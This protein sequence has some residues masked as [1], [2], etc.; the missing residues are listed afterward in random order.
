MKKKNFQKEALKIKIDHRS[1]MLR[2]SVLKCIEAGGRGHIGAAMSL[3]EIL[4]VLYDNFLIFDPKNIN[5]KTRDRFI[6]SKGHGC[7]ALYALLSDKNFFSKDELSKT[8]EPDSILGGHPEIKVPGIE[9]STGALGHGLP[10]GVGMALAAKLKKEKHRVVV[11]IGDGETN[12]GS[13]W[14]SAMSASKHN[15][16]NLTIILDYNKIQSYGFVKDVLDLEPL[17]QKWESFGFNVIEINGH[18]IKQIKKALSCS[19]KKKNK[20][21]I[22][23]CH[24]VKGKGIPVAENNP[25]WHHKNNLTKENIEDLY[26]SLD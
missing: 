11:V 18:D 12:E 3:I 5:L 4:R 1:K 26:R 14:E 2:K 9:A 6:L 15:L 13:I 19:V 8:C 23:I 17:N 21:K 10:I 20:P 7:L 25:T 16:S 22:I 24:T